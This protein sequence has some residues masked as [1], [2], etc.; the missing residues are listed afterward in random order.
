VDGDAELACPLAIDMGRSLP[1]TL[2]LVNRNIL[3]PFQISL[4]RRKT[5]LAC[6]PWLPLSFVISNRLCFYSA[7][8]EGAR[9][10]LHRRR[11]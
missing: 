3:H 2:A 7:Y 9:T 6:A 11:S 8:P 10:H 5:K 4:K 1:D